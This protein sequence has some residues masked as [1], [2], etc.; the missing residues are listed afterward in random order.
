M[1]NT[2]HLYAFFGVAYAVAI[3]EA[4]LAPLFEHES[5]LNVGEVFVA[6]LF[7][8]LGVTIGQWVGRRLVAAHPETQTW[9]LGVY[10]WILSFLAV[11]VIEPLLGSV[12]GIVFR[13]S[14]MFTI[15]AV[16]SHFV[17]TPALFAFMASVVRHDRLAHV[18]FSALVNW[19]LWLPFAI[20][21]T[22]V[23]LRAWFAAFASTGLLAVAGY[24]IAQGLDAVR[25]KPLIL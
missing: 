6:S 1:N 3:F 12:A 8:V 2:R 15:V 10:R 23:P 16:I 5:G 17:L 11:L 19:F 18:C 24:L 13:G 9:R 25:G 22:V 4:L 7:G 14:P 20:D 21:A